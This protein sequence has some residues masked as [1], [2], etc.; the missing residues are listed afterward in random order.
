MARRHPGP[1]DLAR[2]RPSRRLLRRPARRL[3][4]SAIGGAP[5]T[6]LDG[7]KVA[8]VNPRWTYTRSIY[9]G[10]R[11]PH[12][13]LE[14]AYASALLERNGHQTLL[15]DGQLQGLDDRALADAVAEFAPDFTV[16]TTAPTYLFWRCAPPELRVPRQFLDALGGRGGRTVAVGPHGSAT[17]APTLRKLGVD[18]VVRGESEEVVAALAEADDWSQVPGTARLEDGVARSVGGLH[19][20]WFVEHAPLRW[21]AA[22]ITRHEHHHHR[23]DTPR[24]GWGA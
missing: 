10:C 12:L 8:L 3:T 9:F 16:V 7:M 14:L 11:E 6:E 17:P 5:P 15:L 24:R 19:A 21:P 22:W 2:E 13:P 20:S 18:L 1:L 4:G 23:F